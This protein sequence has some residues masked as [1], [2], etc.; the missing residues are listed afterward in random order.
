[1]LNEHLGNKEAAR[2]AYQTIKDKYFDTA[3]SR[4][5]DKYLIRVAG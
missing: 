5:I 1:M 3:I 4:D 2:D